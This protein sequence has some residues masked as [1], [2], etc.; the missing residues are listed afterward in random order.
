[1]NGVEVSVY[2]G[3]EPILKH[4]DVVTLIPVA[5]GG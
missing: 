2:S 1:V 5:H 4:G 3:R